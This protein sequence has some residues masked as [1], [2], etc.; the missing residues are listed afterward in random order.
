MKRTFT[1]ADQTAFALLSGDYNPIHLD[2]LQARRLLFGKQVVH[3]LHAVLWALESL[4][5]DVAYAHLLENKVLARLKVT[6]AKPIGVGELV[7]VNVTKVSD[8]WVDCGIVSNTTVFTKIRCEWADAPVAQNDDVIRAIHTPSALSST[9][10]REPDELNGAQG[11]LLLWLDEGLVQSMFP[12]LS[13]TLPSV[14]LAEMLSLTRLVGMECP[15][16]RSVFSDF[17]VTFGKVLTQNVPP[18]HVLWYAVAEFDERFNLLMVNVRAVDMQGV[19]RAFVRPMPYAQP[20]FTQVQHEVQMARLTQAFADQYALVVGGSRGLGEVTAK[21]LAAGGAEVCLTYFRGVSEAQNITADI[22][23]GGGKAV[24]CAFD[25]Q[26]MSS[27]LQSLG[28]MKFKPT[29]LYYLATPFIFDAVSGEFSTTLFRQF[30]DYY[31]SSFVELVKALK[32]LGLK[33][34]FYPSSVAIDDIPPNMG[35]YAAAKAAGEAACGFLRRTERN[36]YIFVPRL[37]RLATDQTA[38]LLPV[39]NG[40]PVKEMLVH[41]KGMFVKGE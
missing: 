28:E 9:T 37:P 35:E 18:Q 23:A 22:Q 39:Q 36:L 3:G 11:E 24:N 26:N 27:G 19:V 29:H 10:P 34:V 31:V 1:F 8:K 21:I 14:R 5:L 32:P 41:M 12:R 33:C 15:G 25:V 16:L 40:D 20:T 30:C 13:Q 38:T 4:L 2:A 6:F 7:E 17:D